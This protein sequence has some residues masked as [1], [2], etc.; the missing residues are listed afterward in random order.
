MRAASRSG[1]KVQF[2]RF[3]I[4]A[5]GQLFYDGTL[6]VAHFGMDKSTAPIGDTV[7][8][9]HAAVSSQAQAGDKFHILLVRPV[10]EDL[11]RVESPRDQALHIF[12]ATPFVGVLK[13]LA[14]RAPLETDLRRV[15]QTVRPGDRS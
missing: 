11:E 1:R 5:G 15:E 3:R 4:I 6:M 9:V 13:R 10:D 14:I 7:I 2:Y 8:R 12:P